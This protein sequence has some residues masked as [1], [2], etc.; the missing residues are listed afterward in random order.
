MVAMWM[1]ANCG[2]TRAQIRMV[3]PKMRLSTSDLQTQR[4]ATMAFRPTGDHPISSATVRLI[5]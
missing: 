4:H 2:W 3:K 1:G 5:A